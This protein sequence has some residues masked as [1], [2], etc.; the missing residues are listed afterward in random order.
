MGRKVTTSYKTANGLKRSATTSEKCTF[1]AALAFTLRYSR[2]ELSQFHDEYR[3]VLQ[4]R[5][6]KIPPLLWFDAFK[7]PC[8]PTGKSGTWLRKVIFRSGWDKDKSTRSL[9]LSEALVTKGDILDAEITCE[10]QLNMWIELWR[11]EAVTVVKSFGGL[12][13]GSSQPIEADVVVARGM[14]DGQLY[15]P[16]LETIAQAADGR[17]AALFGPISLINASCKHCANVE[18][19]RKGFEYYAET[20]KDIAEGC[21]LYAWYVQPSK[22][23]VCPVCSACVTVE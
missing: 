10:E 5:R 15:W 11:N 12:G 4:R 1:E 7:R 23:L 14:L 19:R 18:F 3:G 20:T 2:Y 13:L 16:E 22:E 21:E 8:K 9:P 17:D 6:I